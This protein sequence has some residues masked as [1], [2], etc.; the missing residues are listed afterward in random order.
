MA[1]YHLLDFGSGYDPLLLAR[2]RRDAHE[3]V[4]F[5][6]IG[7]HLGGTVLDVLW[8]KVA[9]RRDGVAVGGGD[10][11]AGIFCVYLWCLL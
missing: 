1:L 9:G 4:Q 2:C 7:M 5:A 11:E 3:M 10:G 8:M 6:V